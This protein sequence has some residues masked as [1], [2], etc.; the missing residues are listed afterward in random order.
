MPQASSPASP[1]PDGH[2]RTIPF[3][4]SREESLQ[5][6][7]PI[8]ESMGFRFHALENLQELCDYLRE[9]PAV[10]VWTDSHLPDGD[11]RDVL[12]VC[13]QQCPETPVVV[14]AQFDSPALWAEAAEAGVAE[15]LAPPFAAPEVRRC[16]L[17]AAA[18]DRVLEPVQAAQ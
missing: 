9:F 17:A 10:A 18:G 12:D 4:I 7:G 6:L 16:L 1:I 8:A 15:F 11:W 2:P 13:H 14:T 3:L 5:R